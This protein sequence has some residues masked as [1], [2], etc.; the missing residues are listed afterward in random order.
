MRSFVVKPCEW[1]RVQFEC[2]HRAEIAREEY[3]DGSAWCIAC[4]D[5]Q[6]YKRCLTCHSLDCQS[7]DGPTLAHETAEASR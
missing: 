1:P 6:V 7:K 3:G 2:G 4:D 5:F